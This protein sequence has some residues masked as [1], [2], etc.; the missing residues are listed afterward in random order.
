MEVILERPQLS[1]SPI[2]GVGRGVLCDERGFDFATAGNSCGLV[3]LQYVL[4]VRNGGLDKPFLPLTTISSSSSWLAG[5]K[6][7]ILGPL[8]RRFRPPL[9]FVPLELIVDLRRR[10]T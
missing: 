6:S 10:S 3:V 4:A 1:R 8:S 7:C 9:M 5:R 2:G